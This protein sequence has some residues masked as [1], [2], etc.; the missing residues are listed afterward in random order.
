MID[1]SKYLD[2]N[3]HDWAV[4]CSVMC[5]QYSLMIPF[6]MEGGCQVREMEREEVGTPAIL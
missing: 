6:R 5:I 3:C 2:V 1:C 4:S